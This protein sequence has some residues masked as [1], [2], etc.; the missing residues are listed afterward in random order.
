MQTLPF[1][2]CH[3]NAVVQT[4]LHGGVVILPTDTVYGVVCHPDFPEALDRIRA[5]KHRD[6]NKPFQLLVDQVA[7]V[8]KHGAI[9]TATAERLTAFWPG[10]LTL[11]LPTTQ[12]TTEGYR[13]PNHPLLQQLLSACGG[14]L[15]STSVNLSGE[16]PAKNAQEALEALGNDVDLLLDG[17]P[18]NLGIA[19]TVAALNQSEELTILREGSIIIDPTILNK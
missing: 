19:S 18:A 16:P 1:N 11:V 15:R 5:M 14:Y 4:L 2:Q 9:K 7:T 3:L 10:A 12:G 8:W 17:G 6:A 13:V